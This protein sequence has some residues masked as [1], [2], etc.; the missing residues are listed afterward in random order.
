MKNKEILPLV[1]VT[2]N[3]FDDIEEIFK[4]FKDRVH[5][6]NFAYMTDWNHYLNHDEILMHSC[7][8]ANYFETFKQY[9]DEYE[10]SILS[11]IVEK[12]KKSLIEYIDI[13]KNDKIWHNVLDNID[14]NE[15]LH[16]TGF[17][18]YITEDSENKSSMKY[19]SLYHTD[20]NRKEIGEVQHIVT[21][22]IYLNDNYNEGEIEFYYNDN[23]IDKIVSY[24][25]EKGD[26]V[27]FPSFVPYFHAVRTPRGGD[28]YAI[29]TSYNGIFDEIVEDNK[30]S[31]SF[32][33]SP[34]IDMQDIVKN[35]VHIDGRIH[36]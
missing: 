26:I 13:Y 36:D 19:A 32:N 8:F 10:K 3:P 2:K 9:D 24:K 33:R 35:Y 1:Y 6:K 21:S 15:F 30:K 4:F 22:M 14:Y 27:T 25:P 23:G 11:Q 16:E 31:F 12:R 34:Y 17:D 20:A 18:V 28:R 5:E 7:S 29:R